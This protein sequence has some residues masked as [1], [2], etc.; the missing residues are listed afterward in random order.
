[1]LI[2]WFTVGAQALNFLVLVW[3]LKRYLYQPVLAAIDAREKQIALVLADATSQRTAAEQERSA[4]A[5]KNSSLESEREALLA[6]ARRGAEAEHERLLAQARTESDTLRA[7]QLAAGQNDQRR[8]GQELALLA[9]TE[10]LAIARKALGDLAG[11][12]LEERIVE[13]FADRLR[14]MDAAA[15]K[16]LEA[17][18]H[19]VTDLTVTSAFDLS[20]EQRSAMQTAIDEALSRSTPLRFTISP[21]LVCGVRL[22]AGGERLA[23][24]IADYLGALDQKAQSLV[25]A[26]YASRLSALSSP[27]QAAPIR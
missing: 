4:W 17:A 27:P 13:V 10:V 5:V 8:L 23:W 15:K 14:N 1:M 7:K 26:Q 18:F 2:D 6:V 9:R 22:S 11:I 25:A 21:D 20:D 16:I 19:T 24:S 3:L 12:S